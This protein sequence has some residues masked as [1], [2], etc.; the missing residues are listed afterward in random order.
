MCLKNMPPSTK[1]PFYGV[2]RSVAFVTKVTSDTLC[3]IVECCSKYQQSELLKTTNLADI[4]VVCTGPVPLT[5]GIVHDLHNTHVL[6][7]H[8]GV[9][10]YCTI[11]CINDRNLYNK[12]RTVCLC[13]CLYVSL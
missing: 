12:R 13:V 11:I 3:L 8:P 1:M 6:Q 4:S 2:V 5:D 7:H 10:K 9:I